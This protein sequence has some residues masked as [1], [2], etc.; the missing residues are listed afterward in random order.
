VNYYYTEHKRNK[1][2]KPVDSVSVTS[3]INK[4]PAKRK[5]YFKRFRKNKELL[6]LALPGMFLFFVFCY[7]PLY[8]L[9]LP[10]KNYRFDLGFF[11]SKWIGFKNFEFLFSGDAFRITRNT[12]VFNLIFIVL[13]LFMA[14]SFALMLFE[15][16]ARFVKIYQSILFVPF[17]MS[18]IVAG[19]IGQTL[20][21]MNY[22]F[23]NTIIEF[24]GGQAKLWYTTPWYWY[25]IGPLANLWKGLGYGTIIY[26]TALLGID[27]ELHEAAELDGANGA[28]KIWYIS[29]PMIKPLMIMLTLMSIGGIIRADF[30]LFFSFTMD[31]KALY[32]VTDVIDTYVYRALNKLLDVGMSSAASLYQSVVGF[33]LVLLSNWLVRKVDPDSSLF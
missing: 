28:Q 5:I 29:L 16:S 14:V 24:F 32:P 23:L 25:I 30:G 11:K 3:F 2:G 4:K 20:L 7:I 31:S 33:I 26:Y 1:G 27:P 17:F 12:I 13:G 19:Y 6:F 18:W 15:L 22:G 8:G 9:V 21:D 10:F